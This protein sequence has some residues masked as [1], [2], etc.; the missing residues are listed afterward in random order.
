MPT[1][2]CGY[3]SNHSPESF[4]SPFGK[5]EYVGPNSSLF[6]NPYG[7]PQSIPS[8]RVPPGSRYDPIDPFDNPLMERPTN[9]TEFFGFD[10][11]GQPLKRP[12]MIKQ[13]RPQFPSSFG[14]PSLGGG[15]NNFPGGFPG[16]FRGI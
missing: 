4:Q 3:G 8:L 11:F 13:D 12:L 5:E 16:G 2:S 15:F 6:T 1:V 9:P 7:Q 14:S 10:E